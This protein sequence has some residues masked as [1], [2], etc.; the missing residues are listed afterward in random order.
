MCFPVIQ[1]DNRGSPLVIQDDNRSSPLVI[2]DDNWT[3]SP[4][5]KQGQMIVSQTVPE[6]DLYDYKDA[7]KD[8][9]DLQVSVIP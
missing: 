6:H 8:T 4:S 1:D 7:R 2:Q 5:G 3:G 9:W